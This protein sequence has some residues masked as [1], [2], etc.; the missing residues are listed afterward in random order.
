MEFK[1]KGKIDQ[2]ESIIPIKLAL[3][4]NIEDY[5]ALSKEFESLPK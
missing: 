1:E 5:S 4:I 3:I 2:S